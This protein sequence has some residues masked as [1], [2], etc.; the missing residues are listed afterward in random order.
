METPVYSGSLQVL[1]PNLVVELDP[2]VL[3]GIAPGETASWPVYV[4]NTGDGV[5]SD[6]TLTAVL[7]PGGGLDN[8]TFTPP[9][10]S[11]APLA[12]PIPMPDLTAGAPRTFLGTV[13]ADLTVGTATSCQDIYVTFTGNFGCESL[14]CQPDVVVTGSVN[15]EY[16]T[17]N[18]TYSFS[19]D[20][21]STIPYCGSTSVTVTVE[22]PGATAGNIVGLQMTVDAF[23]MEYTVTGDT[24]SEVDVLVDAGSNIFR[25]VD[26]ANH[27]LPAVIGPDDEFDFTF[28]VSRDGCATLDCRSLIFIPQF[29]DDCG[30]VFEPPIQELQIS[31]Y[32]PA[33]SDYDLTVT[34]DAGNPAIPDEGATLGY[35]I[36]A[37][38]NAEP[39]RRT[40]RPTS[41]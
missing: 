12:A 41:S 30:D 22:N 9:S 16:R 4:S 10:G 32:P 33:T 36:T 35:T 14:N 6:G 7:A 3:Y 40:R 29:Y 23:G 2:E 1:M 15:L 5:L 11:P 39:A 31:A 21:I 34:P 17:P 38:Y 13:S 20:P 18:L 19:P 25:F 27:S 24:S 26:A 8:L 37:V 28:D